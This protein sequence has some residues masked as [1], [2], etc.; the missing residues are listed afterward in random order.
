VFVVGMIAAFIAV[1]EAIRT[2]ILASLRSE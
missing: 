2:P 1:A